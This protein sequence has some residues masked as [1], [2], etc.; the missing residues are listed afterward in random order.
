[1]VV[2]RLH[3]HKFCRNN[4]YQSLCVYA[5]FAKLASYKKPTSFD[6]AQGPTKNRSPQNYCT[7]IYYMWVFGLHSGLSMATDILVMA[8]PIALGMQ[9][10][11]SRRLHFAIV[12]VL[13]IGGVSIAASIV[14]FTGILPI[15]GPQLGIGGSQDA[16][17]TVMF[18]SHIEF[19]CAFVA[20]CLPSYRA[21]WL[22]KQD[23]KS[24]SASREY[25]GQRSTRSKAIHEEDTIALAS[26]HSHSPVI[27]ER[28]RYGDGY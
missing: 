12:F 8:I 14:R 24:S 28:S 27:S 17:R 1:M 13:T 4:G 15:A 6:N 2:G 23:A 11:L 9:M 10:N 22:K 3:D 7:A 20:A 26:R 5:R 18:W 16:I 21:L 25:S 19:A